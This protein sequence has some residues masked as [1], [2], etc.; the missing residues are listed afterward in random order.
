MAAIILG[1]ILPTRDGIWSGWMGDLPWL[2]PVS[3]EFDGGLVRKGVGVSLCI[4]N[5]IGFGV[6]WGLVRLGVGAAFAWVQG[7]MFRVIEFLW[8]YFFKRLKWKN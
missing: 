6:D 2:V 1:C 4:L 7:S 5:Q 8:L 3:G